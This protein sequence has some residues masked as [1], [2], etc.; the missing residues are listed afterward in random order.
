MFLP[1]MIDLRVASKSS[2]VMI[3]SEMCLADAQPEP[4]AI[5]ILALIML[6]TSLTPSP[7]IRTYL[8]NC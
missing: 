7:V 5:P 3:I 4:I 6:S 8:S 1:H 2:L